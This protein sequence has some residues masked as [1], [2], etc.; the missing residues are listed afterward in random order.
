LKDEF[1]KFSSEQMLIG[2]GFECM[3]S[4]GC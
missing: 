4:D 1:G 2:R 3:L